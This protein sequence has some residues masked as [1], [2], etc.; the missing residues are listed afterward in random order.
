MFGFF[1]RRKSRDALKQR[2]KLVLSY[3]RA[4]L[5]PGKMEELKSELLGVIG[6]YFPSDAE[7]YDVRFEQQGD[8]M[9]LVANLPIKG[10][11]S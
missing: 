10:E 7:D 4:R 5:T 1:R 3:D 2:L 6:K 11:R 9:V 8:R